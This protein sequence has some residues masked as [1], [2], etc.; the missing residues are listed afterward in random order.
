M[1]RSA[2][3]RWVRDRFAAYEDQPEMQLSKDAKLSLFIHWSFIL[4]ASM[5]G[6]FLNL[7]LWRLTGSLAVNGGYQI[8]VFAVTP[9]AFAW[10][11][12][13]VKRKDRLFVI[14]LG[15]IFSA[16]FYLLVII[17][18]EQVADYYYIFAF[19]NGLSVSFY[20]IGYLVLMFDVS[21][22]SNRLRYMS[23]NLIVFTFANLIGPAAAGFIIS[24]FVSLTGYVIIF[25]IAFC[26]FVITAFA[27]FRLKPID[28]HHKAYYL[29][30]MGL[31]IRKNSAFR[32][33]LA[34]YFL[35][36]NL[37]GV[38][39]FLPNLL[40]FEVL[41]REDAVGYLGVL[42]SLIGIAAGY[43]I[44]RFGKVD[45]I[46]QFVLVSALGFTTASS[47]LLL[48]ITIWTVIGFILLQAFFMPIFGNPTGAYYYQMI[49]RLPLKGELRV[50]ALVM[51]ELFVNAGRVCS[52]GLL[53][54]L[55]RDLHSGF[56]PIVV[57]LAAVLQFGWLMLL[58]SN[59]KSE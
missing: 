16:L 51:R 33:V 47:L 57:V 9:L 21:N 6:V 56:L 53:I 1:N 48:G 25:S 2:M 11:G 30:L 44:S 28:S 55:A 37:Q 45:A 14:R 42:S 8:I 46:R 50:E 40:L 17:A 38:I 52:I 13:W 36:G 18:Q 3:I 49:A 35:Y 23:S 15:V 29:Q 5:S 39:M 43:L 54:Y 32:K 34:G 7:Y 58:E 24:L 12:R 26:M 59:N 22:Q 27:S 4:G 20:W 19:L 41:P 10:A 31:L